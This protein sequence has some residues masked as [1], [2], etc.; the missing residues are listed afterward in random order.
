MRKRVS[1]KVRLSAAQKASLKKARRKANTS[2]AKL[3]RRKAM[4]I[5][6]RRG[7]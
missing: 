4:R 5:R 3:K 1:G 2:K 6:Q 7:L